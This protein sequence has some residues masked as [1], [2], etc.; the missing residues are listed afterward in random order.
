MSD[1]VSKFVL[2]QVAQKGG[3][4]VLPEELLAPEA[5][6]RALEF[7][8]SVHALVPFARAVELAPWLDEVPHAARLVMRAERDR[9]ARLFREARVEAERAS[10]VL[11]A[12]EVPVIL[13]GGLAL[14]LRFYP[15]PAFRGVD[16]L[17]FRIPADRHFDA[18]RALGLGGYRMHAEGG[19][20][21]EA[22]APAVKLSGAGG[23][24]EWDRSVSGAFRGFSG[25][26]RA[27]SA[28]DALVDHLRFAVRERAL[29]SPVW[30]NDAHFIASMLEASDW[31]VAASRISS[32]R[33]QAAAWTLLGIA[34]NERGT[35]VP[36]GFLDAMRRELGLFRKWRL[37]RIG[38][39]ESLFA[40]GE[41]RGITRLMA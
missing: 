16:L 24:A 18:K 31:E 6:V 14:A 40:P 7:A 35:D 28:A 25:E 3:Q 36:S 5:W 19:L 32:E 12:A 20:S 26:L 10:A 22:G 41:A 33:L 39:D 9:Q 17:R 13:E 8:A 34:R 38:S 4:N 15:D 2:N 37:S 30:V 21:R 23:G 29:D 11:V 1:L 27:L